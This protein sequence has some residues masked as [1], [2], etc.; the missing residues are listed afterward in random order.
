VN[1]ASERTRAAVL[2]FLMP[3]F[4]SSNIVIGRAVVGEVPPFTLAFFRWALA[5][6]IVIPIAWSGIVAARAVWRAVSPKLFLLGFLGM[7]I[8]GAVVYL[9]LQVTTATNAT[10]IYT[11][12]PVFVILIEAVFRGRKIGVPEAV[13][14]PLAVAGVAVIVTRGDP[15]ALLAL[16]FNLGDLGILICA[17]AWAVYSVV[18]KDGALKGLPTMPLFAMIAASGAL[19]LFPFMM[20]ETAIVG[21]MPTSAKAWIAILALATVSSVLAFSSYQYGVK[22][23]GPTITSIML[24]VMP[25]YGVGLAIL[26]LGEALRGYHLAGMALVLL[27]VVLATFPRDLLAKLLGRSRQ[28]AE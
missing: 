25:I 16:S 13:G 23:F 15:S 22:V 9:S 28:P 4:F 6:A 12:S 14:I 1:L 17:L 27:G 8:C 20:V 26:F 18:L 10:L 3:L 5:A 7:W 24:Y 19:V 2:L 11:T 21:G